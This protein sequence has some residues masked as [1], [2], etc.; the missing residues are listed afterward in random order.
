M[1]PADDHPPPLMD[2]LRVASRSAHRSSRVSALAATAAVATAPGAYRHAVVGFATIY[3]ELEATIKAGRMTV[4]RLGALHCPQLYRA[5]ALM[6]DVTFHW[7]GD[8]AAA[9]A[10]LAAPPSPAVAAYVDYL[11]SLRSAVPPVGLIGVA[12]AMHLA[13]AAGGSTLAR[14]LKRSLRLGGGDGGDDR[15]TPGLTVFAYPGVDVPTVRA[16]YKERINSLRLSDAEVAAVVAARTRVFAL[17]DA[18]FVEVAV[19]A[20]RRGLAATARAAAAVAVVGGGVW[21][22]REVLLGSLGV[23]LGM[24]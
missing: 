21:W 14:I 5:A 24:A 20:A 16:A 10:A 17:N 22:A 12:T 18:V 9:A 19:A 3:A 8:P 11:R 23:V 1:A 2:R 4:P 13:P 7:G 15:G 6:D